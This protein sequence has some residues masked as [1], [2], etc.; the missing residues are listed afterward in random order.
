MWCKM[1]HC[2]YYTEKSIIERK[3]KWKNKTKQDMIWALCSQKGCGSVG[4]VPAQIFRESD[5]MLWEWRVP[6]PVDWSVVLKWNGPIFTS[7]ISFGDC[8]DRSISLFTNGPQPSELK[9]F[10]R[11]QKVERGWCLPKASVYRFRSGNWLQLKGKLTGKA[12]RSKVVILVNE[13]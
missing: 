12:I 2:V 6:R 9:D 8:S 1:Q 11:P 5:C 13:Q 4:L 7:W 3:W 10:W